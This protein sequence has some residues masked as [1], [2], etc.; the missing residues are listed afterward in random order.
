MPNRKK[1]V[2]TGASGTIAGLV[3]PT[4]RDVHDPHGVPCQIFYGISG[5]DHAFWSIVNARK[6]LGY[7]P[8]DNSAVRF[9]AQVAQ[10]IQAAGGD[11]S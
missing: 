11:A 6:V 1:V 3:L 8:E 5:N 10:H 9:A 7:A 2:L 4:L